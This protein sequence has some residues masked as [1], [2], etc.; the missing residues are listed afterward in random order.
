ML[1][2]A[3][4]SLSDAQFRFERETAAFEAKLKL[5]E[6]A[7]AAQCERLDALVASV[8]RRAEE[9]ASEADAKHNEVL[10]LLQVRP[11]ARSQPHTP[12]HC[13]S[14]TSTPDTNDMNHHA[15]EKPALSLVLTATLFQA[16]IRKVVASKDAAI[17]SLRSA[18]AQREQ[19]QQR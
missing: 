3:P 17:A 7:H 8:R 10:M 15:P 1:L 11:P 2:R 13:G 18:L 6:Q 16:R 9:E 5:S 19:N 14:A 12:Q 4:T